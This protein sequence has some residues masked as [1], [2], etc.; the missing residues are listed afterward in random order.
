[1]LFIVF[2]EKL[3]IVKK[4]L[5][6]FNGL[7]CV[8]VVNV[9]DAVAEVRSTKVVSVLNSSTLKLDW[10]FHLT[11]IATGNLQKHYSESETVSRSCSLQKFNIYIC[12]VFAR[13]LI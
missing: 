7:A 11:G 9:F 5:L 12:V 6:E 4:S 8:L 13:S 10:E 1:M 2:E 3:N